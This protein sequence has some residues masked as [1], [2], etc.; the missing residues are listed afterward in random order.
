MSFNPTLLVSR[1]GT[2]TLPQSASGSPRSGHSLRNESAVATAA[3]AGATV[4]SPA[5]QQARPGRG[6][7]SEAWERLRTRGW[8]SLDR[9]WE[10]GSRAGRRV[11]HTQE[12]PELLQVGYRPRNGGHAVGLQIS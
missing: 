7:W 3:V 4:A 8:S 2:S 12:R 1:A 10:M 6:K 5:D 9:E 11:A